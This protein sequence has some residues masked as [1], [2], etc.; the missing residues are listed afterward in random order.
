MEQQKGRGGE[1]ATTVEKGMMNN[2]MRLSRLNHPR[3]TL[4]AMV[5]LAAVFL[6]FGA[7]AHA[8]LPELT[9]GAPEATGEAVLFLRNLS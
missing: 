1:P 2:S 5:L 9:A 8:L 6:L 4:V 3:G 7:F